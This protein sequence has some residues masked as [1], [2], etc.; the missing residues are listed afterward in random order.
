MAAPAAAGRAVRAVLP[1]TCLACAEADPSPLG[2][3]YRPIV[4]AFCS[5]PVSEVQFI[6]GF[7]VTGCRL[8][9][10]VCVLACVALFLQMPMGE[11]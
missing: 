4:A 1:R 10:R 7:C 3:R 11:Q 8:G 5:D 6:G 2:A 9:F